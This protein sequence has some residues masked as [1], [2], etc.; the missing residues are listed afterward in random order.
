MEMQIECI[1]ACRLG[2]YLF[3]FFAITR[4]RIDRLNQNRSIS[5]NGIA[6]QL[7]LRILVL[8]DFCKVGEGKTGSEAFRNRVTMFGGKK[9]SGQSGEGSEKGLEH[10]KLSFKGMMSKASEWDHWRHS[11]G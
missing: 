7:Y 4:C 6:G 8:L 10:M 11:D 2:E 1:L 3:C 5:G 9:E